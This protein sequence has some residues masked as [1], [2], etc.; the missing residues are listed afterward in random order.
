[1]IWLL[2]AAALLLIIA[3]PAYAIGYCVRLLLERLLR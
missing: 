2:L 1:M 3:A